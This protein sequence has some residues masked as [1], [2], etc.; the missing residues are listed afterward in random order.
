[1]EGFEG[2]PNNNSTRKYNELYGDP[3]DRSETVRVVAVSGDTAEL[4]GKTAASLL[5]TWLP[6]DWVNAYQYGWE[7]RAPS[8]GDDYTVEATM[9]IDDG[10]GGIVTKTITLHAQRGDETPTDSELDVPA[11]PFAGVA[12]ATDAPLSQLRFTAKTDGTMSFEDH[13]GTSQFGWPKDWNDAAP[14]TDDSENFLIRVVLID[15]EPPN[16]SGEGDPGVWYPLTFDRTY[17]LNVTSAV[18]EPVVRQG[19]WEVQFKK[20]GAPDSSAEA[21]TLEPSVTNETSPDGGDG[22][23]PIEP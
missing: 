18:S 12:I 13:N 23:P 17:S 22:P 10:S 1:M 21:M 19:T 5:N 11:G 4:V 8:D 7:V 15:G 20:N 3:A 9:E 14:A 16:G 2:L 6:L